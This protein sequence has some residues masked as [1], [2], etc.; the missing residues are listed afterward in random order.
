MFLILRHTL[1][2]PKY[3]LYYSVSCT[4]YIDQKSFCQKQEDA[5]YGK[6]NFVNMSKY[7]GYIKSEQKQQI[8][9]YQCHK[10]VAH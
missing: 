3:I 7:N 9:V 5:F 10:L 2:F 8:V 6:F 1:M 4:A